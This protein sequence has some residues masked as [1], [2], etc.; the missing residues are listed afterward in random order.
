VLE[1][2]RSGG[3]GQ[4]NIVETSLDVLDAYAILA[5]HNIGARIRVGLGSLF[6]TLT[7][8][9]RRN[10]CQVTRWRESNAF[11]MGKESLPR[12]L[13]ADEESRG[14]GSAHARSHRTR[15]L[16]AGFPITD[17]R[18][19]AKGQGRSLLKFITAG[20]SR[21]ENRS[22]T[23]STPSKRRAISKRTA[24]R[25]ARTS[26]I[27][28]YRFAGICDSSLAPTR[29]NRQ[30]ESGR[31]AGCLP[32]TDLSA[33]AGETNDNNAIPL[34]LSHASGR[35]PACAYRGSGGGGL[36]S[37]GHASRASADERRI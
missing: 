15:K 32:S 37:R 27:V 2:G 14:K 33:V 9:L 35:R 18:G 30:V 28:A 26:E 23:H 24:D 29:W 16:V 21:A 11:R 1:R 17:G 4:G 7:C 25:F 5:A 31:G 13:E 34:S 12:A 8:S 22:L 20:L 6:F 36:V 10:V 19:S 3:G